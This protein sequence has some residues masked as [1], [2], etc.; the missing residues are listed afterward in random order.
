MS[1]VLNNRVFDCFKT[2]VTETVH[3]G[4]FLR[5]PSRSLQFLKDLLHRFKVDH[6]HIHQ[7]Q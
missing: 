4:A 7:M 1:G 2:D 3:D 6:L 5:T